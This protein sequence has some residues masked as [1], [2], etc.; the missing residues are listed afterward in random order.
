MESTRCSTREERA[1][2]RAL[3]RDNRG[4]NAVANMEEGARGGDVRG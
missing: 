4:G 2:R 1:L 3:K